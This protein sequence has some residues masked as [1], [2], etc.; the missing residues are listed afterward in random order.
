MMVEPINFAYNEETAASNSFQ[1]AAGKEHVDEIRQLAMAEFQNFVQQL[2][3]VGVTV[4][5]FRPDDPIETTDEVFPNNWVSFHHDGTVVTYP[6]MAPIRRHER[7]M[8]FI[9]SLEKDHGFIVNN[10]VDLSH[11]ENQQLFLEGTGSMVIDYQA[12]VAYGNTSARTHADL[13][14]KACDILSLEPCVFQAVDEEG[15]DIYHTNVLM[16]VAT[17]FAVI[18]LEAIPHEDQRQQVRNKLE[19]SGLEVVALSYD[20]MNA[21][22]GNMMEVSV[23][24][25]HF[26]VMS[27]SAKDS[28]SESQVAAIQQYASILAIPIPT[29]ERFGGGSVRCMMAGIF[30]PR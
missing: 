18:C 7:R 19:Q 26:I 6:M 21:F 27:R 11:F 8:D 22:A 14:Q 13:F 9:T 1:Q 3:Q 23:N 17:K 29:I 25:Q 16:C 28:L 20:Q 15:L 5:T 24:D 12:R 2:R 4:I 10:V 30:L